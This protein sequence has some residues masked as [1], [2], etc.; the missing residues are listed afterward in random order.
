M[1]FE[2]DVGDMHWLAFA[3][4]MASGWG[5]PPIVC[6]VWSCLIWPKIHPPDV[7]QP[8]QSRV[9]NARLPTQCLTTFP[10]PIE[11]RSVADTEPNASSHGVC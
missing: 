6:I 7:K 11:M 10:K 1:G 2:N 8:Q 3:D 4:R 9:R 5:R